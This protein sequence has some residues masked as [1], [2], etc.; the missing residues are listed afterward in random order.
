MIKIKVYAANKILLTCKYIYLEPYA[1]NTS[2]KFT[3]KEISPTSKKRILQKTRDVLHF[4]EDHLKIQVNVFTKSNEWSC[5]DEFKIYLIDYGNLEKTSLWISGLVYDDY[6]KD[7]RQGVIDIFTLWAKHKNIKWSDLPLN[8]PLK[9]DYISSCL[10]YSG[11]TSELLE[12][13]N[14]VIDWSLIN[15]ER[16]FLYFASIELVGDK[17][18]FGWETYTFEDCFTTIHHAGGLKKS[19]RVAFFNSSKITDPEIY[20]LYQS[21]TNTFNR[22]N[23]LVEEAPD[24]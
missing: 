7:Y 14:Y 24:A 20:S 4:D 3:F 19:R 6:F 5:I 9:K 11:T 16:D 8:S 13:D 17:G 2:R 12:R 15:E 1:P 22:F 21:V 18:Y 10:L 23:F